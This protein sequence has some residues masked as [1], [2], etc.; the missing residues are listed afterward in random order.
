M[1][2]PVIWNGTRSKVLTQ[3]GLLTSA[4]RTID[5]DGIINFI[6]NPNA[7]INTTG[8]A[9]YADTA[10][11]IPANG[12][13]G[14][15]TG[16]TFTRS[17]SS[18]L[19]GTASF[20]MVQA[21][22]TSLQGKGVSYDF[23][24]D[25]AYQAQPLGISFNF[26]ASSTFVA[27][28]GSTPPLNDGTTNTN[29]GNSDIEVFIYDV[30]NAVLIPV[31][32]QVITANGA[33]NFVYGGSF[34]TASNSTSYRLI[35]HVATTSANAT[36]WTFKFDN[37]VVGPSA[38]VGSSSSVGAIYASYTNSSAISASTTAP[39]QFNVLDNDTNSAV[40]TGSAW[41]FTAPVSGFY[42]VQVA[43]GVPSSSFNNFIYKNGAKS[44]PVG[45]M[46]SALSNYPQCG[47][48]FL[49]AG[50]YIDIRPDGACTTNASGQISISLVSGG[51]STGG[52]AGGAVV[53]ALVTGTP[54]NPTANNPIIFPTITKDTNGAYNATTGLYTVPVSG[55]YKVDAYI[56]LSTIAGNQAVGIWVDSTAFEYIGT[57]IT[58]N[59]SMFGAGTVYANAGQTLSLRLTGN[60]S[61]M[62]TS[63]ASFT[64]VGGGSSSSAVSATVGVTL[65][66]SGNLAVTAGTVVKFQTATD[67]THGGYNATTGL[68]T[69]PIAGRYTIGCVAFATGAT[70]AL[71]IVKNGSSVAFVAPSNT[72]NLGGGSYTVR[73]LAGDTIGIYTDTSNTLQRLA[74]SIIVTSVSINKVGNY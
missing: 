23:S 1:S 41:K 24:I 5:Y 69:V 55:F 72:A 29:A 63:N 27:S 43:I 67:D 57:S 30:T 74:S 14:T 15:A 20:S 39:F 38:V 54:A 26:N 65:T 48:I 10:A 35:F 66:L 71:Y 12:T 62:A 34:Q 59:Q 13:G 60:A 47:G 11:N 53:A 68:Y 61:G 49:N 9:T 25:S 58:A 37:V 3:N 2:S 28:N 6:A 50:D 7:E 32:P 42:L 21:N 18:P 19:A 52:G 22:S 70:G 73:A 64:L 51:S 4:G 16:L 46:A 36:G 17:T 56:N 33:N 44:Y 45:G 8:W 31:T 40:T